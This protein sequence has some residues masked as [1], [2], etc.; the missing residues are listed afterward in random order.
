MRPGYAAEVGLRRTFRIALTRS[1]H[2][3]RLGVQ[4]APRR[5]SGMLVLVV[6]AV[7]GAGRGGLVSAGC[8]GSSPLIIGPMTKR[9]CR[10]SRNGMG[11]DQAERANRGAAGLG[12]QDGTGQRADVMPHVW[13]EADDGTDRPVQAAPPGTWVAWL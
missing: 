9:R 11:G 6:P 13:G 10:R 4:A 2:V 1:M 3:R 8:V 12:D 5:T 7:I